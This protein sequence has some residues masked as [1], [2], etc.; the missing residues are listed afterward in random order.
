MA[1]AS[2][3]NS[4]T[5]I[6]KEASWGVAP[7][8]GSTSAQYYPRV[9][10]DLALSR[11]SFASERINSTAQ[12][13]ESRS[14][15]DVVGGTLSD[16][17]ATGSHTKIYECLL[18][19]AFAAGATNT[20]IKYACVASGN[21]ITD[22][23]STFITE[24]FKVGD[25]VDISGFTTTTNN[26]RAM[27]MSLTAGEMV[28]NGLTLTNEAAGDSVTIA[29]AGKKLAIPALVDDRTDDSFTIERFYADIG[30]SRKATGCKF[31]SAS[32]SI[33][34]DTM[35]TVEFEVQGKDMVTSTS[36]YFTAPVAAAASSVMAGNKAFLMVDGAPAV[37]VT[38]LDFE[39]QG[40]LEASSVVGNLQSDNTRPSAAIFQGVIEVSGTITAYF[41][42]DVLFEKFRDE[43]AIVLAF[44]MKGDNGNDMVYKMG[45]VK[46]GSATPSDGS[47]GGLTQEISFNALYRESTAGTAYDD[48]CIVIQEIIAA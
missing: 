25:V 47:T 31:G 37:L 12:V 33:Q 43:E 40:G 14:G 22:S 48:S 4:V 45:R 24:G 39:V 41:E 10:F 16:E 18:R 1:F 35:A 29:V 13:T 30:V 19:G 6:D 3:V 5:V 21:K 32:F 17:I 7:A 38:G 8:A 46:L 2:G 44:W 36:R 42:N 11:E 34:P 23:G 9:S 20:G 27:I 26:G 15:T 28:I